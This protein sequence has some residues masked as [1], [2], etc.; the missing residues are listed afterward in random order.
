MRRDDPSIDKNLQV[1]GSRWR[2]PNSKRERSLRSREKVMGRQAR[3]AREK[4][5]GDA[6][7]SEDRE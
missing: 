2:D 3:R 4:T 1:G 5:E 7:A 6:E